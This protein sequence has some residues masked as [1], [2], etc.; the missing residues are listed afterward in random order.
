MQARLVFPS[1]FRE[2]AANGKVDRATDFLV[3]EHIFREAL[4]A[5]IGT[6]TPFAQGAGT[7]VDVE[8]RCQKFLIFRS[9]LLDDTTVFEPQLD[10][11][12]LL[13]L[14]HGGIIEADPAVGRIL[15]RTGKYLPVRE[16]VAP[17]GDL[18][19][20]VLNGECDVHVRTPDDSLVMTFQPVC[21]PL[22]F[23]S[24]FSPESNGV[25]LIQH[26]GAEYKLT[27]IGQTHIGILSHCMRGIDGQAPAVGSIGRALHQLS[28]EGS[29]RPAAAGQARAVDAG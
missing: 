10:I 21:K 23:P 19:A 8:H 17:V 26:T 12:H 22:L 24:F 18:E 25:L 20:A 2:S 11:A 4:N 9:F 14:M 15:D 7:L 29:H 3:E 16:V 13:P 5:I 1:A 28:R 27:V 6:D